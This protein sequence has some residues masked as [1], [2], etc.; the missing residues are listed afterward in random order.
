MK[1]LN[2]GFIMSTE[3]GLETQYLNWRH[4]LPEDL[5]IRPEWIVVEWWREHGMLERLPVPH[6]PT[7]RLRAYSSL[8][9]GLARGPFDALFVAQERILHRASGILS[10]QPY[11]ITADVTAKQ[12]QEFGVLYDKAGTGI[13]R[14][15]AAKHRERCERYRGAAALFPWSQWAAESMVR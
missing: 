4:N 7:A 12:L 6:G 11:F 10:R 3:V 14:Y 13:E 2:I 9:R 1:T 15:E 8:R 5:G